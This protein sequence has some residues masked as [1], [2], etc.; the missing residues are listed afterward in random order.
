MK[1]KICITLSQEVLDIIDNFKWKFKLSYR[2]DVL[3]KIVKEFSIE[4]NAEELSNE[5]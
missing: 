2:N 3:E 1:K 4:K 5:N